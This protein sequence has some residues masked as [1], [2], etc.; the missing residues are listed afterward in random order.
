MA[1]SPISNSLGT[2]NIYGQIA[3]GRRINSAADDA[4]GLAISNKLESQTRGTDAATN[5]AKAGVSALNISDGA[6]GQIND[7]L[8][9]IYELGVKAS[10]KLTNGPEELKAIQS[11]ISGLMG[12]IEDI[13]KGTE[14]NTLKLL[15][16]S[17]A[18][19]DLATNP[20]GSGMSIKMANST[21]ESLGIDGFDVTGDFDL[22]KISDAI[23]KVSDSRSQIGATT[24]A[25]EYTVNRNNLTAE[26]LTASK[27]KIEDLDIFEAVSKMKKDELMDTYQ[28]ML[29]K[30]QQE[31]EQNKAMGILQF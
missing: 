15:D 2:N 30:K 4:A 8:Q 21:L 5:N 18:D 1:I 14:Y 23:S 10:N 17:M 20:D 19:M 6:L 25:L 29:Q 31:N 7:S 26:N 3:S 28:I 24:N 27:S 12:G 16:G 22:S 13:A 11:E 9:R